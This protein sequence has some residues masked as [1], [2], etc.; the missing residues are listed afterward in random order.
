MVFM[1]FGVT[2]VDLT[3]RLLSIKR[4]VIHRT[5]DLSRHKTV[6]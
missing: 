4:V 3:R 6:L 1:Q 2:V 5:V